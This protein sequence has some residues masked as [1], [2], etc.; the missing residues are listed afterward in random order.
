MANTQPKFANHDSHLWA[1]L[2]PR[3]SNARVLRIDFWRLTPNCVL[4]RDPASAQVILPGAHISGTH[5]TLTWNRKNGNESEII[6]QDHSSGGTWVDGHRLDRGI[7]YRL[8]HGA[9]ISFGAPVAVTDHDSLYDYPQPR[10]KFDEIYTR[11]AHLGSGTYGTVFMAAEKKSG[12]IVAVKCLTYPVG[13]HYVTHLQSTLTEITAL[14]NIQHPHVVKMFAS[15]HA[16][17]EPIIYLVLEYMPDNLF[18]YMEQELDTGTLRKGK[19]ARGL[20]E[21]IVREIMYQLCHAMSH[22]HALGITHRDLK[23]ENILLRVVDG[24]P[25]IK[26]ADFGLAKIQKDLSRRQLMTSVCGSSTYVAPEVA[27]PRTPGYDHYADSFSAGVIMFT[28]AILGSP[29]C[30]ERIPPGAPP[31]PK[32][33]WDCLTTKVLAPEG[34]DFLDHLVRPNPRE[35]LSLAGALTHRWLT[36]FTP[37]HPMSKS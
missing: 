10:L 16:A 34:F 13:A 3:S 20:P 11:G 36:D 35:R 22:I 17:H 14:E 23:P 2:L 18:S 5:A 24:T 15:H 25:F 27:D 19:R 29:W 32:M 4:G 28:M 21:K 7:D 26:V 8:L 12:R 1:S 37:V 30:E 33:R 31:L 6:L 9:E